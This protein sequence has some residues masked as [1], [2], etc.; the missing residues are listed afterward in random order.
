M[1][2]S[3]KTLNEFLDEFTE[4]TDILVSRSNSSKL[5]E[6]SRIRGISLETLKKHKIFW[7]GNM[8]ELLV[9]E[10]LGSLSDFGLISSVD[11]KPIYH[12][13]WIIPIMDE[14]GRTINFV[15]YT[16]QKDE[17]YVYGTSVYYDRTD[18]LYGLEQMKLAYD[19]G[20]AIVTE[21]ITDTLSIRALGFM[22]TFA[23]C[24][25][26]PSEYK[27]KQL[28]RLRHG[29][30]FIHDRDKA[31]DKTRRHWITNRYFRFNTP[32]KYKD[33]DETLHDPEQNNEAWFKECMNMAIDWIKQQEHN[34][35]TCLCLEQTMV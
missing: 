31:G 5:E 12:D 28:N 16:N 14:K 4:Y 32:L 13:R 7:V 29:V 11:N 25:T 19:L 1:R 33:A 15:G 18:T 27:M 30:I 3:I 2:H 6:L 21:G 8:V 26:R 10:Y 34:G 35:N 17:R 9:P 23:M 20:Y 24:G 22:N